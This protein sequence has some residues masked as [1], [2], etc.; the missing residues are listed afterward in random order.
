MTLLL[1]LLA[2][3]LAHHPELEAAATSPSPA[4]ASWR[5]VMAEPGPVEAEAVLS[6]RWSVPLSGLLDLDD[7]AA[8]EAGLSDADT[9]I[10]LP[11]HV[12]THPEAGAFVVDTG[13]AVDEDGALVGPVGL[14]KG[15]LGAVEVVEPLGAI[16]ARQRAPLAG[17]LITHMHL[18][19]VLGLAAVPS[20]APVYV[21]PGEQ[22]HRAAMN[23]LTRR[24]YRSLL[25]DRAPLQVWDTDAAVVI[26]GIPATDLVGDG[27]IWALHTPGHTAGSTAFLVNTTEGPALY[28]GDTCHTR[29]GWEHGVTPGTFTEDHEANAESLRLLRGLE[30]SLPGLQVWVGHELDGDGTGVHAI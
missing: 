24:T 30:D 12:L 22:D 27:S 21:G 19:H 10:A 2:C 3:T 29:W 9:P 13:V 14:V 7:P 5:E 25:G 15:Y 6:A 16:L 1:S 11:V 23:A 18:D 20:D 28:T 26:E 8:V 17:V 4:P